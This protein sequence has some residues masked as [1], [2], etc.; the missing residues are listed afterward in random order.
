MRDSSRN[1]HSKRRYT[2]YDQKRSSH[3]RKNRSHY[4]SKSSHEQDDNRVSWIK[5]RQLI[6]RTFFKKGDRP[7]K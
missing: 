1:S 4:E 6:K 7:E 5:D 3:S 2:K